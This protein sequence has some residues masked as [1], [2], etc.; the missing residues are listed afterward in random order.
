MRAPMFEQVLSD[1]ENGHHA[2]EYQLY[3]PSKEVLQKKLVEWAGKARD[4]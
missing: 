2:R 1:S 4:A 3:L